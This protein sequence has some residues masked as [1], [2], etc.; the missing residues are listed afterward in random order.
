M[1]KRGWQP[2][3]QELKE[4]LGRYQNCVI[5]SLGPDG[6]PQAANVAFS[7]N[8]ALEL[9][10]GTSVSS[11][12]YA[13]IVRDPRVAVTV[14]DTDD[15]LT[16]QYQGTAEVLSKAEF[17]ARQTDHFIKLPGSLP[18]KDLPDQVYFLI[19][20]TWIRFSDCNP[21]PWVITEFEF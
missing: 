10:I 21:H 7:E 20:P 19:K 1:E 14:T 18:F 2:T 11:R 5:S 6:E 12:K 8:D 3:K 9:I 16:V 4:F 15:R 13:N 17:M